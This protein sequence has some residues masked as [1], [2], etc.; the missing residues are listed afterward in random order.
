MICY[1]CMYIYIYIYTHIIIISLGLHVLVR[2]A[3]H[4]RGLGGPAA[5]GDK[6]CLS[7]ENN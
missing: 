6:I 7:K 3:R 2:G 4:Q 5:P 1:L